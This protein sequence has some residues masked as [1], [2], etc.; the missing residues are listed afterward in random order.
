[1]ESFLLL[2]RSTGEELCRR[3]EYLAEPDKSSRLVN[4]LRPD[5]VP[6]S[7]TDSHRYAVTVMASD[8][9]HLVDEH[10]PCIRLSTR[11]LLRILC[12]ESP[13]Q[14]RLRSR[15]ATGSPSRTLC[16]QRECPGHIKYSPLSL[17]VA[18]TPDARPLSRCR[19]RTAPSI[20]PYQTRLVWPY[21]FPDAPLTVGISSLAPNMCTAEVPCR[22]LCLR[23]PA[24]ALRLMLLGTSVN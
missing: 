7:P 16:S 15:A 5:D 11:T 23:K 19:T 22:A 9:R 17:A 4:R 10:S 13:L 18:T 21:H 1:M 12:T 24:A 8:A 20:S 3:R 6:D 2:A 14:G